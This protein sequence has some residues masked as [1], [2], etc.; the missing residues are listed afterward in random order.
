MVCAPFLV[1]LHYVLKDAIHTFDDAELNHVRQV[2]FARLDDSSNYLDG[3]GV[4][5]GVVDL[6]VLEQDLDQ[7]QL[8]E[9]DDERT[10]PLDNDRK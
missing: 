10:V 4:E 8:V 5:F 7:L 1:A 2:D 3:E 9:D 6:E